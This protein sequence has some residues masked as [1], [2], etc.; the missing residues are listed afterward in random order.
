MFPDILV[1]FVCGRRTCWSWVWCKS[2]AL[3]QVNFWMNFLS[4]QVI[5]VGSEGWSI[6]HVWEVTL[7]NVLLWTG[8]SG[9]RT[10]FTIQHS[11]IQCSFLAP[12]TAL[13]MELAFDLIYSIC[14]PTLSPWSTFSFLH[15]CV[16][17]LHVCIILG[18]W[19][20]SGTSITLLH[21]GPL[22][23]AR[24]SF[25]PKFVLWQIIN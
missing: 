14:L 15:S 21:S 7:N 19:M 17:Y 23:A 2:W 10:L 24:K 6:L 8:E 12:L 1:F 5:I 16:Y 4:A 18:L 11:S 9:T 25:C 13:I 20:Q 22:N 3:I